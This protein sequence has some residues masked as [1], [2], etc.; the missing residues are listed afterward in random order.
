MVFHRSLSDYKSPQVSRSFLSILGDLTNALF[1]M[2]STHPLIFKSSSSFTNL[3]WL[4][5]ELQ[6]WL[7]SLTHPCSTVCL[8]FSISL[9][10]PARYPSF[11]FLSTWST[12]TAKSTI[13]YFFYKLIKLLRRIRIG[14]MN[15]NFSIRFK[16][17]TPLDS[18]NVLKC[19]Q[20][21]FITCGTE[22]QI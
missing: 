1:W 16:L 4:F 14:K 13:R 10:G 18:G 3:W 2:V 12:G 15:Y 7:V 17:S 11:R 9:S 22:A 5:Q 21:V 8:F 19:S 6:L 20:L